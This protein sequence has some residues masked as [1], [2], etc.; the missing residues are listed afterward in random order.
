[1]SGIVLISELFLMPILSFWFMVRFLKHFLK[2]SDGIIL[3]SI[4]FALIIWTF[5]LDA[6]F[7]SGGY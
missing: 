5:S 6:F 2:N 4:L 7:S 1:M 3:T